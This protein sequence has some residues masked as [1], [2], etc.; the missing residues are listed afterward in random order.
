MKRTEVEFKYISGMHLGTYEQF[1]LSVALF[2]SEKEGLTSDELQ[3]KAE[4]GEYD[5]TFELLL[6]GS[7]INKRIEI[8][9]ELGER[10]ETIEKYRLTDR[11]EKDLFAGMALFGRDVE[12]YMI[13]KEASQSG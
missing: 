8:I 2:A 6:G 10:G 9:R 3:K 5:A 12:S 7:L 1:L 13:E 4:F 11:G